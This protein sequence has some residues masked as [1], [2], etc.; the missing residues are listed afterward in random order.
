MTK[1]ERQSYADWIKI[2]PLQYQRVHGLVES[3]GGTV[4]D[5]KIFAPSEFILFY[6]VPKSSKEEFEKEL[7]Q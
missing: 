4:K 7:R 6:Y 2:P 1:V 3:Y 5:C